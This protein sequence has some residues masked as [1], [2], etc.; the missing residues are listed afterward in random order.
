MLKERFKEYDTIRAQLATI[1]I[2]I[3]DLSYQVTDNIGSLSFADKHFDVSNEVWLEKI[4]VKIEHLFNAEVVV[5]PHGVM[6]LNLNR[7]FH[8]FTFRFLLTQVVVVYSNRNPYFQ[9]QEEIWKYLSAKGTVCQLTLAPKCR[10]WQLFEGHL[11]TMGPEVQYDDW[12]FDP[13]A[14]FYKHHAFYG[15]DNE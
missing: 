1:G 6:V 12:R 4:H 5:T 2:I 14:S 15:E 11:V 3:G 7:G 10:K 13:T 9:N 8:I